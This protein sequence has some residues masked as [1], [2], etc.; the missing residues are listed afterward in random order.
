MSEVLTQEICRDYRKRMLE[1]PPMGYQDIGE[2]R[3]LRI[4]LQ[5]RCGLTEL[6]ALNVCNGHHW[7]L[8]IRCSEIR[9]EQK[10]LKEAM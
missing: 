10:A 9:E 6:E 2:R 1:L 8:T 3:K 4:E 7:E 5:E